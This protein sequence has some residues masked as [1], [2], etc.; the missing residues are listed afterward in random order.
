MGGLSVDEVRRRQALGG[1]VGAAMKLARFGRPDP[2]AP[3]KA[4]RVYRAS[5]EVAHGGDPAEYAD[6]PKRLRPV[7]LCRACPDRIEV[8]ETATDA[9]RH[10]FAAYLRSMHYGRL[11]L[12]AVAKRRATG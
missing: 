2:W 4:R 3:T 8:P 9:E 12:L 6:L 11:T 1:R 7:G 10:E 5:F